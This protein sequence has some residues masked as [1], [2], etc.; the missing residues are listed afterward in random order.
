MAK[1]SRTVY[2]MINV[3]SEEEKKK[4]INRL[5][6]FINAA[7]F[8]FKNE[9]PHTTNYRPLLELISWLDGSNQIAD[10]MTSSPRMQH[11]HHTSLFQKCWKLF[12]SGDIGFTAASEVIA[13]NSCDGR[14][15]HWRQNSQWAVNLS[16]I[17][18]EWRSG[19]S[20]TTYSVC[21][22]FHWNVN[23]TS[24]SFN[25]TGHFR[26]MQNQNNKLC[27][28]SA[29][30]NTEHVVYAMAIFIFSWHLSDIQKCT[31]TMTS[32]FLLEYRGELLTAQEGE[33]QYIM[34]MLFRNVECIQG[35]SC[36]IAAMW[37]SC[38]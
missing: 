30:I 16:E 12:L 13:G 11:T 33:R 35:S 25:E 14:W 38:C 5:A 17:S 37:H 2:T 9:I 10:F 7:Y 1:L 15:I 21:G 4:N 34:E 27:Y 28:S 22:N 23:V 24:C 29:E 18:G 36:K 32:D 20:M 26:L 8:L 31:S 3:Q 6:D 19:W